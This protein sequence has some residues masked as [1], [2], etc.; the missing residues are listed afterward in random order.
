MVKRYQPNQCNKIKEHFREHPYYKLCKAVFDEFQKLYPTVVMTPEQLFVDASQTLDSILQNGDKL[1]ER[2]HNLWTEKYNQ[3]REQDGTAGD[4]DDTKAEVAMLFYMVMYGVAT[5]NHSHYRSTLQ[6][7]LLKS[8]HEMF[9]PDKCKTIE[10]KLH[11]PVN[12]HSDIM[13]TWMTEYF[14]SS[15]CLTKEI[16]EV[17]HPERKAGTKDSEKKKEVKCYTLK[18]N[19]PDDKMRVKRIDA[20]MRMMVGWKWIEEPQNADDFQYFFNGLERNCNLVWH[21]SATVAILTGLIKGLLLQHYIDKVTGV[22]VRSIVKNQFNRTP[23]N[24][25]GR[26]DAKNT[27]RIQWVIDILDYNKPLPLPHKSEEDSYDNTYKAAMQAV[28]AEELHI[29]KD[30]NRK[31]E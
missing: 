16:K 31:F 29:T 25:K 10:Q 2:C 13:K 23:D 20:V 17:L 30:L 5:V 14:V 18:Y 4:K 9:G 11:D 8:I 1:A 19:C 24:N 22:S 28:F 15:Q 12:L 6:R 27:E 21:Q 3:Y 7:I 26:V